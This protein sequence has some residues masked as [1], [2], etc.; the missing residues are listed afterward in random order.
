MTSWVRAAG[1]AC[2]L[3]FSFSLLGCS[4]ANQLNPPETPSGVTGNWEFTAAPSY[5]MGAYLSASG[6]SVTGTAVMQ[7]AFPLYCSPECCGGPFAE[8]NGTLTGTID[9]SGN[10]TVTSAVPNGG[11][12]FTMSGKVAN[13]ALTNGSYTLTGGCPASGSFTGIE[14]PA[15]NGTYAGTLTSA[16]TGSSFTI[17][18]NLA[19]SST[20]NS[21]G[22]FDVTSSATLSGYSCISSATGATPLDQNSGLLGNQFAVTMNGGQSGTTISL[23]GALSEDGKSINATYVASGGNCKLDY[24]TGTLTW[25]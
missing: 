9:A 1:S 4:A 16:D 22:F 10:L 20:M 5:P 21:R 17:S 8:F 11:P 15:L 12:V 19:Q 3:I 7:M 23:S 24:G 25:Q 14:Y 18:T 13:G 6:T 2:A